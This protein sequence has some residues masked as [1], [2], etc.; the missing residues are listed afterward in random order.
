MIKVSIIMAT[1]NG[2]RFIKKQLFSLLLQTYAI[3][4]V[5]IADDG[6]S[7]ETVNIIMNFINTHQLNNWKIFINPVNKG[8]KRNFID[9]I[10]KAHG[11]VI[12]YCDQDDIWFNNK[13]AEM[14]KIHI[15]NPLIL[16]LACHYQSIDQDDNNLNFTVDAKAKNT[17]NIIPIDIDD[18][19]FY[20]VP[21]GCTI[22]FRKIILRYMNPTFIDCGPDRILCRTAA[23]LDGLF[24]CDI[25]LMSHRFHDSNVSN[26]FTK[27]SCL[28]GSSS[29]ELRLQYVKENILHLKEFEILITRINAHYKYHD[30]LKQL[31][32]FEQLR[33]KLLKFGNVFVLIKLLTMCTFKYAYIMVITD[34]CYAIGINRLAGRLYNMIKHE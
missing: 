34:F 9:L 15:D 12:F 31:I 4:E 16:C 19:R 21:S 6:S 29:L 20:Y 2:A 28:H 7:D 22:S 14:I 11:D 27:V 23:L 26:D 8:W 1:Y 24:D 32:V 17:G 10:F 33:L 25:T 13:V 3:D 30:K 5:L 18:K